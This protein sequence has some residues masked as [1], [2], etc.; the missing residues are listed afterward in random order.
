MDF[1]KV[2]TLARREKTFVVMENED[3]NRFCN[4]DGAAYC[5]DGLPVMSVEEITFL[6][7]ISTA[8]GYIA[9]DTTAHSILNNYVE[10]D[11]FLPPEIYTQ[12]CFRGTAYKA[13]KINDILNFYDIDYFKPFEKEGDIEYLAR[14]IKDEKNQYALLLKRGMDLLG[15]IMP[16]K[17]NDDEDLKKDIDQ[18]KYTLDKLI[19]QKTSEEIENEEI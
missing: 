2:L 14:K 11:M 9:V 7:G 4:I 17:I 6:T 16:A 1:R 12:I 3:G 10:D 5:I 15:L 18:Y 13:Y 19:N 8:K